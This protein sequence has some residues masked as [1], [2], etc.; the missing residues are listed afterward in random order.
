MVC[1][2]HLQPGFYLILFPQYNSYHHRHAL[3]S[4]PPWRISSQTCISKLFGSVHATRESSHSLARDLLCENGQ[5]P[6]T[7]WDTTIFTQVGHL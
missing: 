4:F 7:S 5:I 3:L 2:S 1:S 6:F